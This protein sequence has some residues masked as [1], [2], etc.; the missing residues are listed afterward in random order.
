MNKV[1][2]L[3]LLVLIGVSCKEKKGNEELRVLQFNIWQEGTQVEDGYNAI[4][5]EIIRTEADLIAL[6]EVRNYNETNLATRL[7]N[8]LKDKGFTYYSL[9]SQDTG[10]LSR[11]PITKQEAIYPVKNDQGSITKALIDK[12]GTMIAFYSAHLDYRNCALYLP[13]AYDGT[14][15][16][17]LEAPVT[18]LNAIRENNLAS[19][20]DDAIRVFIA[21][22]A[23]EIEIGRLVFLG[24]DFNEP[25]H[26]DWVEEN[27]NR[28]DHNGVV[29]NWHN[30]VALEKAGY[31]DTY[32]EIYPNPISH[33]G[34]TYP[35]DNPLV[36]IKKLAWSPEADDRDRIDF[37]FYQ[38]DVK[39][40]LKKVAI[41]GPNGSIARNKRIPELLQ[42]PFIKPLGVWPTDHKAV[43]AIFNLKRN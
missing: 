36:D 4:I 11:Y 1:Y 6:S 21:D 26:R 38:P 28:Y 41:L 14:T 12:N 2:F 16:K 10:I 7:V 5:N 43:L 34:F 37:I 13:R 30:T 23:K 19:K 31:L 32:R 39:L 3:L 9:K 25:S 35:A 8:T 27:K 24:G 42:D 18:D 15:W 20:R 29:M 33:P 40:K 22:A 17:K